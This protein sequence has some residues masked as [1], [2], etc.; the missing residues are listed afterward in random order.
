[1]A[2]DV[3]ISNA[4]ADTVS[5]AVTLR[6]F[7]AQ[8]PTRISIQVAIA[9]QARVQMQGRLHKEAPWVDIGESLDRSCLFHLDPIWSVRAVST[10]TGTGSLVSVWAAWGLL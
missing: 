5:Q 2:A 8:V 6:A 9:G 3:L 1:M 7:G 10:G 4:S